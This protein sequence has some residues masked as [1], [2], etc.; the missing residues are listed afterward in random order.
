MKVKGI[1]EQIDCLRKIFPGVGSAD[2]RLAQQPFPAGAEGWFAIPRWQKLAS[3]YGEALSRI[4]DA[5]KQTQRCVIFSSEGQSLQNLCQSQKTLTA[6]EV[7]AGQQKDYDVLVVP[8]QFGMRYKE[9]S[10]RQARD[11]MVACEFGLDAFTVGIMLLTHP[12]RL[13]HN[14]DL[15]IYCVG[16][17]FLGG[18]DLSDRAPFFCYIG[19]GVEFDAFLVGAIDGPYGSASG[20]L[21]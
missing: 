15:W 12:E 11:A 21:L 3:T 16:D 6:L 8:C 9:C 7:L 4:L 13:Q 18:E 20:F 2:E 5:I 10:V 17:E 14:N 19:G 1:A